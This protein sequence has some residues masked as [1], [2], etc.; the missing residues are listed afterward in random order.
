MKLRRNP[1]ILWDLLPS[2]WIFKGFGRLF[3]VKIDEIKDPLTRITISRDFLRIFSHFQVEID[4]IEEE[5][6]SFQ[7]F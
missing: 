2:L 5:I 3:Q 6:T 7:D 4:E 1:W